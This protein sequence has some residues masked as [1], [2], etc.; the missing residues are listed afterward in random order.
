MQEFVFFS[1]A[2][3]YGSEGPHVELVD[4]VGKDY[5]LVI[6]DEDGITFL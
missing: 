2:C 3:Q 1:I 6:S 5:R 4:G